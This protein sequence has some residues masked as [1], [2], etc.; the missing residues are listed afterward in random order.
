MLQI[1]D[2]EKYEM[3]QNAESDSLRE[4]MRKLGENRKILSFSEEALS[5]DASIQF[6]SQINTF[7]NHCPRPFVRMDG[8]FFIL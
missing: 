7:A 1:K 6:L 8:R 3:L 4:D 5:F 2:N